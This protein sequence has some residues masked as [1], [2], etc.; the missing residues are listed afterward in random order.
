[1]KIT[2][3]AEIDITTDDIDQTQLISDVTDFFCD[4]EQTYF[5]GDI[6]VCVNTEK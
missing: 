1:M 2:V 5:L 3:T 4:N 6:K